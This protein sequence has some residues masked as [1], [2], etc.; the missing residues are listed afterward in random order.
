M[1]TPPPPVGWPEVA[2]RRV[3]QLLERWSTEA[4]GASGP[5][6]G[7][8]ASFTMA[9]SRGRAGLAFVRLNVPWDSG[10]GGGGAAPHTHT[11]VIPPTPA[12][13]MSKRDAL[14]PKMSPGKS[15][16]GGDPNNF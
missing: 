6:V 11:G 16:G 13:E 8:A 15:T 4:G 1:L 12:P 3:V 5:G 14:P 10:C 2:P 7:G 9:H